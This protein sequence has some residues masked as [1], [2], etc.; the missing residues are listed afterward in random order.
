MSLLFGNPNALNFAVDKIYDNT[1]EI[2][3]QELAK[4]DEIQL[5][6]TILRSDTTEA[7]Y[8]IYIKIYNK[9][10]ELE[11]KKIG[12]MPDWNDGLSNIILDGGTST[13]NID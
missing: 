1:T 2:M 6:R 3:L 12:Q 9:D 5:G 7:P 11:Y 8:F 13:I 10:R 4:T